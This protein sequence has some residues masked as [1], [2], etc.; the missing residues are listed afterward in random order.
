MKYKHFK[1]AL[2]F[3]VGSNVK[4]GHTPLYTIYDETYY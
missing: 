1:Q 4:L 3:K 2:L